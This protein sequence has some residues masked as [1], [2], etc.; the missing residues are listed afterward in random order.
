MRFFPQSIKHKD[1]MIQEKDILFS[2]LIQHAD[3][4]K[5]HQLHERSG[6]NTELSPEQCNARHKE[7]ANSCYIWFALPTQWYHPQ[8]SKP[9]ALAKL[10][11][12]DSYSNGEHLR[13]RRKAQVGST[14]IQCWQKK[15]AAK[16]L[17]Q[18]PSKGVNI[19][20]YKTQQ[21]PQ[22]NQIQRSRCSIK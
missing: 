4:I 1:E 11:S 15:K 18:E 14:G 10:T 5:E 16:V 6:G 12:V 3:E 8:A 20:A 17:P 2:R 22:I 7:R 13:P 9:P 19:L 21:Q